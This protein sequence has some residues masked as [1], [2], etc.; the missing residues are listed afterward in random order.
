MIGK[1]MRLTLEV[2]EI[3]IP[4]LQKASFVRDAPRTCL[5]VF[6]HAIRSNCRGKYIT[7]YLSFAVA[8]FLASLRGCCAKQPLKEVVWQ[9]LHLTSFHN[10]V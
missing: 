10:L 2:S 6:S 8:F 4:T 3:L 7:S 1:C 5:C 9:V